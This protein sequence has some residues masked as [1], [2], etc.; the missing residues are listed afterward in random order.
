MYHRIVCG[1]EG[2]QIKLERCNKVCTD[3]RHSTYFVG[4]PFRNY[5]AKQL[6]WVSDFTLQPSSLGFI[7]NI[8]SQPQGPWRSHNSSF[9]EPRLGKYETVTVAPSAEVNAIV[10]GVAR[11]GDK[12][13]PPKQQN[14]NSN[15]RI[16]DAGTNTIDLFFGPQ[17]LHNAVQLT[18]LCY[19]VCSLGGTS[20]R[21]FPKSRTS[22]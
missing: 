17:K 12:Y 22:H 3:Q 19:I 15:M 5:A 8:F 16:P 18:C 6:S 20:V 21:Q 9:R 13:P 14:W 1:K 2:T 4:K 7:G 10:F 11:I